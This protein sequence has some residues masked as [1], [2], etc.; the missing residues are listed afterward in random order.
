VRDAAAKAKR[1]SWQRAAS[2]VVPRRPAHALFPLRTTKGQKVRGRGFAR[3]AMRY[4][5]RCAAAS[6]VMRG[7]SLGNCTRCWPAGTFVG[8]HAAAVWRLTWPRE[9]QIANR[10]GARVFCR[11]TVPPLHV[12]EPTQAPHGGGI[13]TPAAAALTKVAPTPQQTPAGVWG[14]ALL[15]CELSLEEGAL[16]SLSFVRRA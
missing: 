2:F 6:Q 10:F 15:L 13:L 9:T 8:A 7:A 3:A 16:S 1:R 5:L 4:V 14:G 11:S 12:A